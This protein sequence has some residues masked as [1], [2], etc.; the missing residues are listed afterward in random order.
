MRAFA[1]WLIICIIVRIMTLKLEAQKRDVKS[2]TKNMVKEG[3]LPAVYYGA[4]VE[5]TPVS[6]PLVLFKKVLKEAGG[7]TVITL[8]ED[9]KDKDVLI[10][11]VALDPV[12][13]EPIHADFL[14]IDKDKKVKV[15]VPLVF[16]GESPAV[17]SLGGSLVKVLHEIEIEGFPKDLPHE[18]KV[19]LG[20]LET[21][22][23]NIVV[24]DLDI[25]DGIVSTESP[26]ETVASI[27][28]QKEEEEEAPIEADL[29]SIEVEKK[30]KK[31]EE[32]EGEAK[33][34]S[35]EKAS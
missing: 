23:S 3:V 14:V 13:D 29:S 9:G 11:E 33:D 16:E 32:G 21:L 12:S 4:K 20:R 15:N 5:S 19:Q 10:Q 1:N 2:N 6:V 26:D 27:A 7:S 24:G 18:I 8:S 34:K 17:K 22:E 30:G 25:P 31:D 28:V 35:E